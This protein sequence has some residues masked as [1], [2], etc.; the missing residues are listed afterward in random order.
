[1]VG[2]YPHGASPKLRNYLKISRLCI[3]VV[4][5][6]TARTMVRAAGVHTAISPQFLDMVARNWQT[7]KFRKDQAALHVHLEHLSGREFLS[8]PFLAICGD[9]ATST[10]SFRNCLSEEKARWV[11]GSCCGHP[12]VAI[13]CQ[14]SYDSSL[15]F[16]MKR[17]LTIGSTVLCHTYMNRLVVGIQ[18]R[19]TAYWPRAM[20]GAPVELKQ[21][22]ARL[23]VGCL[24]QFGTEATN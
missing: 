9:V 19:G 8:L 18:E 22:Y 14:V 11:Q 16:V 13:V 23:P 15:P 3:H 20:L 24:H 12:M 2:C 7:S 1:M 10:L 17:L 6:I 5:R 21:V 4:H